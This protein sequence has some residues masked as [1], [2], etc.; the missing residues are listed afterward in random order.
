MKT[1][2]RMY[3]VAKR[4]PGGDTPPLRKGWD[5]NRNH[6]GTGATSSDGVLAEGLVAYAR[7]ADFS[8][9]FDVDQPRG[10]KKV[11]LKRRIIT[12]SLFPIILQLAGTQLSRVIP[13]GGTSALFLPVVYIW[14]Q[15]L[16]ANKNAKFAQRVDRSCSFAH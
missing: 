7:P 5:G 9:S 2:S 1:F 10:E 12:P 14:I 8:K 11:C 15:T 6:G 13:L 16:N 3:R 4:G